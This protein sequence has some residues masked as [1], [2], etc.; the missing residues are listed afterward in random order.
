[1]DGEGDGRRR[2]RVVRNEDGGG[3]RAEGGGGKVVEARYGVEEE[4]EKL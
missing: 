3:R 4:H 1:M 2:W